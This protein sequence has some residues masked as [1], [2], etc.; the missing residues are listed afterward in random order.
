MTCRKTYV[1]NLWSLT[2]GNPLPFNNPKS[3]LLTV[4]QITGMKPATISNVFKIGSRTIPKLLSIDIGQHTN[5]R[6]RVILNPLSDDHL[7]KLPKTK[8]LL[9]NG[10]LLSTLRGT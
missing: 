7:D 5:N 10:L 8:S 2:Y 3:L 1:I 4:A 9:E 6:C